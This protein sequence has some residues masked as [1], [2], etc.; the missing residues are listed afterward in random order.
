MNHGSHV[1]EQ[2]HRLHCMWNYLAP[3]CIFGN[4]GEVNSFCIYF[5]F[6]LIIGYYGRYM[7]VFVSSLLVPNFPKWMSQTEL[8]CK[9]Q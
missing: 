1:T 3:L 7:E 8:I 5:N 6:F 9:I 2:I 4:A